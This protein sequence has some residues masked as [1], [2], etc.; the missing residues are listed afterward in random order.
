MTVNSPV[1]TRK[2]DH[3]IS[4]MFLE[5][6]SPRA[7]SGASMTQEELNRILEAARWAP[8]ASNAQPWRFVCALRGDEAFDRLVAA[9]VPFNQSW[10]SKASALV[11][12]ASAR[13]TTPPGQSEAKPNPTHAFDAGTAWGYMAL[14]AH[15]AGYISHAMG[16]FDK[17][18]MAEAVALPDDHDLHAVVAIGR[19]G[20]TAELPEGLQAREIPNSRRPLDE[21]A[22]HGAF[23]A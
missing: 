5:R 13:T 19:H 1:S 21:L 3:S 20:E 17:A 14:Q 15:L 6:W 10:A 12:V 8:S 11:V 16:G 4:E 22:V 23:K 9:L 7:F 18:A 2:A